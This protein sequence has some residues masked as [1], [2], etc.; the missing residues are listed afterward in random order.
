[1]VTYL[2]T[3][4]AVLEKK[5]F[6]NIIFPRDPAVNLDLI[7]WIIYFGFAIYLHLFRNIFLKLQNYKYVPSVFY[8]SKNSKMLTIKNELTSILLSYPST[9]AILASYIDR[10]DKKPQNI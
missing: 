5:S 9:T 4:F 2:K 1:M 8:Y 6:E 7:N 3:F 10:R